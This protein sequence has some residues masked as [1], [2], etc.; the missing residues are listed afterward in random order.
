MADAIQRLELLPGQEIFLE[1]EQGSSAYIVQA[2]EIEIVKKI[3]GEEKL[4]G[5]VGPGGIIGEMALIDKSVR[6]A[7]AKATQTSTVIVVTSEMFEQKLST[8]DPF[9]RALLKIMAEQ[10]RSQAQ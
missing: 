9:L 8:A 3:D 5:K 6:M 2:G 1:G 10:I 4:L 7:S